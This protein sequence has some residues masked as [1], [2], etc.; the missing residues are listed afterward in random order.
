MAKFELT[1]QR[2]GKVPTP[3]EGVMLGERIYTDFTNNDYIV[4]PGAAIIRWLP[5]LGRNVYEGDP[6]NLAA[7]GIYDA[8]QTAMNSRTLPFQ[9]SDVMINILCNSDLHNFYKAACRAYKLMRYTNDRSLYTKKV[10]I[11]ALGWDYEDLVDKRQLMREYLGYMYD[12]LKTYPLPKVFDYIQW[13]DDM[14]TGVF[15]DTVSDNAQLYIFVQQ[16][17]F[18]Y[19]GVDEGGGKGLR[20]TEWDTSGNQSVKNTVELMWAKFQEMLSAFTHSSDFARINAAI[21]TT[22]R[23]A[24]VTLE[25][26]P[27]EDETVV[28]EANAW[29]DNAIMNMVFHDGLDATDFT[30]VDNDGTLTTDLT[31][32]D[33]LFVYLGGTTYREFMNLLTDNPTPVEMANYMRWHPKFKLSSGGNAVTPISWGTEWIKSMEII[34]M[35]EPLASGDHTFGSLITRLTSNCLSTSS[36]AG[37]TSSGLEALFA[38]SAFKNHPIVTAL[39]GDSSNAYQ[40]L[41]PFSQ[42]NYYAETPDVRACHRAF[43]YAAF[44]DGVSMPNNVDAAEKKYQRKDKDEKSK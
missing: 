32:A 18:T 15:K 4:T 1:N 13:H 31:S 30:Y 26:V 23:D 42:W 14:N 21:R 12:A 41:V 24:F 22:Y 28:P 20:Y 37:V 9:R 11:E 40:I 5:T 8:I 39:I 3:G 43:V 10:L 2:F 7:Q 34:S 36:S 44:V 16:A 27:G 35:E 33:D 19:Q 38:I 6:I 17:Y 25:P 29:L